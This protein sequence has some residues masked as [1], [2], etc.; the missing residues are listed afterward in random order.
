MCMTIH[1]FELSTIVTAQEYRDCREYLFHAAKQQSARCYDDS[2]GWLN[3]TGYHSV[4]IHLS[5]RM[6]CSRPGALIRLRIN[7]SVLLGNNDPTAL[8]SPCK[9]EVKRI[10]A[11]LDVLFE[12]LPIKESISN[13]RLFRLDLCK[14]VNLPTQEHLLEYLRLFRKGADRSHWQVQTFG[15]ERDQHSVR[16]THK[17]YKVTLY[18]KLF[19]LSQPDRCKHSKEPFTQNQSDQILRIETALLSAG[20]REQMKRHNIDRTLRW[21]KQ[22]L[23]LSEVGLDIMCSVIDMVIPNLSFYSLQGAEMI[24]RHA[25]CTNAKKQN[26]L[27]FMLNANRISRLDAARLKVCKNGKKRLRQ[28]YELGI[29]PITIEARAKIASLPSIQLLLKIA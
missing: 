27:D 5:L 10:A 2:N 24:I 1:T 20:I 23:A 25:D 29:N 9:Q 19:E 26:I 16:R 22:M 11:L 15:D 13:F 17:H 7:P 3:Y 6:N 18:D 8:F 28:L 4:G 12:P 14:N 21:S